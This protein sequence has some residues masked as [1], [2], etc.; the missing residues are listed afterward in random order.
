MPLARKLG[1]SP[2]WHGRQQMAT[3]SLTASWRHCCTAGCHPSCDPSWRAHS[4]TI[5]ILEPFM[6]ASRDASCW[7][8]FRSSSVV[9]LSW[10]GFLLS[11]QDLCPV[12][13]T[14][15]KASQKPAVLASRTDSFSRSVEKTLGPVQHKQ[16]ARPVEFEQT[17]TA[18]DYS[19]VLLRT[20]R[21]ALCLKGEKMLKGVTC[22]L[23]CFHTVSRT[24]TL[25]FDL[26]IGRLAMLLQQ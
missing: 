4:M 2:S 19:H 25:R 15:N 12:S 24:P 21:F 16:F 7:I 18:H 22:C 13:P 11:F 10:K 3:G 5:Q 8:F 6:N 14:D 23:F 1:T 20:S 17:Y 9:V 26:A